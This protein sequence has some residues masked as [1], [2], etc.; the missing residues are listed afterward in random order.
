MIR[1]RLK[2]NLARLKNRSLL[3][4][5]IAFLIT[6]EQFSGAD[7][8]AQHYNELDQFYREVWGEHVH[9]GYWQTGRETPEQAVEKLIEVL[10]GKVTL[11][12]IADVCDVG[13]GY[14]ATSRYLQSKYQFQVTGVTVSQSQWEYAVQQTPES[15]WPKFLLQDWLQNQLKSESFDL[16]VSIECFS[17][18]EDKQ[19]YFDEIARV[20]KPGGQATIAIWLANPEAGPWAVRHLLRPICQEGRLPSMATHL[21]C[22]AMISQAGLQL[23][24]LEDA[25]RHVSKTWTICA[26][27]L[28]TKIVTRSKY[29]Q[30][31]LDA[32]TRNR[33]FALTLFRILLAYWTGAMQYGIFAIRKP[34]LCESN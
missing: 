11:P 14:G 33:I 18:I 8:V 16:V 24:S 10:L 15:A 3:S 23:L 29:R 13:C 4:N 28:A 26:R 31:L 17:H 21:E 34:P 9:H 32:S 30:T 6:S 22:E 5:G 12:E 27:R 25:S 20:L 2:R 7:D 19:K 1:I